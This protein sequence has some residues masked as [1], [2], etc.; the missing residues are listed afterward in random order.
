MFSLEWLSRM[1]KPLVSRSPFLVMMYRRMRDQLEGV[2]KPL[3]TP[4]GFTLA[5]N[6]TMAKGFFEPT[7]TRLV[8]T[9]LPNVDVF[10]NVGANVG[11]YCCHALNMGKRAIAFEPIPRNIRFLCKNVKDNGWDDIEIFPIA[12]TNKHGLL[13]IYGDNTGASLVKGWAGTPESQVTVVPCSTMDLLIG[14]RLHGQRALVLVDVEGA[15]KWMLEGARQILNNDPKPIWIVE[16]SARDHQPNGVEINPNFSSTFQIFFDNGYESFGIG[17]E[18][19]SITSDD[20]R[21]LASGSI[22]A[23]THNFMFREL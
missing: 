10:V 14:A 6:P 1:A 16:I 4:W 7:E 17:E 20:V 15:E 8:R 21:L 23:G 19:R 22:K 3:L 2:E 9:M 5:G 18:V 13:E 11:Y 12:L